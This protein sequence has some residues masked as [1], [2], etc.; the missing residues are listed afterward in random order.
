M[1]L[2]HLTLKCRQLHV[3][4]TYIF[5]LRL[6][7]KDEYKA[8]IDESLFSRPVSHVKL[9]N[10]TEL[11]II[12]DTYCSIKSNAFQNFTNISKLHLNLRNVK[13]LEANSFM[14]LSQLKEL[15]LVVEFFFESLVM[16]MNV[17]KCLENLAKFTIFALVSK[18]VKLEG[19]SFANFKH[20]KYV[21]LDGI[22]LTSIHEH[23]FC[24]EQKLESITLKR[25]AL[26]YIG[27]YDLQDQNEL[28]SLSIYSNTIETI[29]LQSFANLPCLQ[30]VT[31]C[32]NEIQRVEN[33]REDEILQD[34][35][36]FPELQ[37]LCFCENLITHLKPDTFIQL[38][39]LMRLDLSSNKLTEIQISTF[40]GLHQL[41]ILYLSYN[42]I[43][44]I[45]AGSFDELSKL[46]ELDLSH[47]KLTRLD[48]NLF[49]KLCHLKT[50]EVIGNKLDNKSKD[51]VL[52]L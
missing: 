25:N 16:D 9:Y 17:L 48:A 51:M 13:K 31:L 26:N 39:N 45:E 43:E 14:G 10:D 2:T 18:S 19:L 42:Q 38:R 37:V 21:N 20:L 47:N 52:K 44:T 23:F 27:I 40:R 30:E 12:T 33:K 28:R 1:H 8:Q 29:N 4:L 22:A 46:K 6:S 11:A 36:S 24:K 15:E 32:A 3:I 35:D 5:A 34:E 41:R 50:L 7:D 49:C